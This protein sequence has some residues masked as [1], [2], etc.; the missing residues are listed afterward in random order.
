VCFIGWSVQRFD[1]AKQG[2]GL[3]RACTTREP[4]RQIPGSRPEALH[5]V[6]DCA[7]GAALIRAVR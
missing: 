2:T 4:A 7:L 6:H 1:L 5:V 3:V